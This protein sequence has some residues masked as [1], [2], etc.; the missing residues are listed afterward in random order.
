ML[1][2][3]PF[4]RF[5]KRRLIFRFRIRLI[6]GIGLFFL[7]FG[8]VYLVNSGNNISL[9]RVGIIGT[10]GTKGTLRTIASQMI[11]LMTNKTVSSFLIH[12][13]LFHRGRNWASRRIRKFK[14]DEVNKSNLLG[15]TRLYYSLVLS[16]F[17][18][19]NSFVTLLIVQFDYKLLYLLQS[20]EVPNISQNT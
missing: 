3:R 20:S 8:D 15:S 2:F 11:I 10:R 14:D 13:V 12:F 9:K 6:I 5:W 7:D 17:L 16:G 4:P 1:L 18:L 19:Y